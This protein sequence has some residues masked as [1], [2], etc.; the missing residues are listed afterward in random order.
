MIRRATA[1]CFA[2]AVLMLGALPASAA[3]SGITHRCSNALF[4]YTQEH[5]LGY[6]D[7]QYD[8]PSEYIP[9][10]V[11]PQKAPLRLTADTRL[12]FVGTFDGY[13]RRLLA[14]TAVGTA[15]CTNIY[16]TT[17][18][19]EL[20]LRLQSAADWVDD[21]NITNIFGRANG[22]NS[23]INRD[24]AVTNVTVTAT[25]WV[26][27]ATNIVYDLAGKPVG[28][29][30]ENRYKIVSTNI[31]DTTRILDRYRQDLDFMRSKDKN[32]NTVSN[33]I[34]ATGFDEDMNPV[35]APW[36][37]H[38]DLRVGRID[39]TF[40]PYYGY[41]RSYDFLGWSFSSI[42]TPSFK[43]SIGDSWETSL[44]D[45]F[46]R[47]LCVNSNCFYSTTWD[48]FEAENSRYAV[49]RDFKNYGWFSFLDYD[50]ICPD[51]WKAFLDFYLGSVQGGG[52]AA[53]TNLVG[54]PLTPDN[55]PTF[56]PGASLADS[57]RIGWAEWA[58]SNAHLALT[59]TAIVGNAAMPHLHYE[60]AATNA[61]SSI[62]YR[63]SGEDNW[64]CIHSFVDG[65]GTGHW[66]R[67]YVVTN[68]IFDV[69]REDAKLIAPYGAI[70]RTDRR[71]ELASYGY[72][73]KIDF[74]VKARGSPEDIP[75]APDNV[76]GYNYVSY[77]IHENTIVGVLGWAH[78]YYENEQASPQNGD[79]LKI[80]HEDEAHGVF[81][82]RRIISGPHGARET[83]GTYNGEYFFHFRAT[84]VTF[85]V[86]SPIDIATTLAPRPFDYT[87]DDTDF[88]S[89][90]CIYPH[91]SFVGQEPDGLAEV[92]RIY[93][94]AIATA[95]VS[96]NFA[97][98]V[99]D[100]KDG[101]DGI[102][103]NTDG[104]RFSASVPS[105]HILTAK[106]VDKFWL[107]A[108]SAL[109]EKMADEVMHR[110]G[111]DPRKIDSAVSELA[112]RID[113]LV[114]S[115]GGSNN[116]LLDLL[117]RN[118]LDS[119]DAVQ[120]SHGTWPDTFRVKNVE[121][122]AFELEAVTFTNG[123][124]EA[125]SPQPTR[126]YHHWNCS[127]SGFILDEEKENIIYDKAA[128]VGRLSGL[129]AV[130]WNFDAMKRPREP[131]P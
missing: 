9:G 76:V 74:Y 27:Y 128:A 10:S 41:F 83:W 7:W 77:P 104:Y 95:A 48:L 125:I 89:R 73:D 17:R 112:E 51:A 3:F 60:V 15:E 109:G 91:P 122:D 129:E 131:F 101:G 33:M 21:Y 80:A 8:V 64:L 120:W 117:F 52:Y 50:S 81:G 26:G 127:L 55:A 54:V 105:S 37:N 36:P 106:Q 30:L 111:V 56:S 71:I 98:D 123:Q 19:G 63:G 13:F 103:P 114:T 65:W 66:T 99:Y 115:E 96:T 58:G 18:G 72:P 20:L 97:F 94:T 126:C 44:Y 82:P 42:A 88:V 78:R 102:I 38:S 16:A 121:G 11:N 110:I 130:K 4:R 43:R 61:F 84:N 46:A 40:S 29:K 100:A 107:D 34:A 119:E 85:S 116:Y 1:C 45:L 87:L 28:V 22:W 25:N 39:D 93:P 68:G 79:I 57:T 118:I 53:M 32:P 69:H 108:D 5:P 86:S 75:G 35:P 14:S 12:A 67:Y 59:D 47:R 24:Y 62:T 2:L 6:F 92:D 31:L 70:H 113:S 23:A 90:P 49:L 124:Y